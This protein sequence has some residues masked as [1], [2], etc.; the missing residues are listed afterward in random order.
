MINV[1]QLPEIVK[2]KKTLGDVVLMDKQGLSVELDRLSIDE[3]A[4]IKM[5]QKEA[6]VN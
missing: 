3:D 1:S 4:E 6:E 2:H 5:F